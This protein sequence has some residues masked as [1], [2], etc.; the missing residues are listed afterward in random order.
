[1]RKSLIVSGVAGAVVAGVLAAVFWTADGPG[2]ERAGPLGAAGP[3]DATQCMPLKSAYVG[4]SDLQNTTNSPIQIEKFSLVSPHA[5]RLLGVDLAPVVA[6]TDGQTVLL[7]VGSAYPVSRK[8][9][10]GTDVR[11]NARRALPMT[12]PPDRPGHSWNVVFGLERTAAAG[13]VGYYQIQ[14]E[15]RGQQYIWTSEISVRLGASKCS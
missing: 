3:V 15:W 7:G 13:S 9:L 6:A 8:D 11:W 5:V 14:Y 10:M 12:M 2:A 4:L 1:V